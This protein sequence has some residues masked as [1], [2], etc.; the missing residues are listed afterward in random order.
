MNTLQEKKAKRF[1]YLNAL[2]EKSDGDTHAHV[3]MLA[4]GDEIK[5]PKE[6]TE[7]VVE[8]L[9]GENLLEDVALNGIIAITH[10]G[11]VKMEEALSSPEKETNYFPPVVNVMNVHTIIGS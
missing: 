5:F 11:V 1:I 2:Y 8:Y 10:Y 7:K 4:L 9:K 3:D 6:V